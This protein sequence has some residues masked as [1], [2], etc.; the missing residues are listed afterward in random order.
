MNGIRFFRYIYLKL[1]RIND[2]PERVAFGLGIGVF[3]GV[4][5]GMGP[6][7][8]L[9][10]AVILRANRAA[11][12]V[13]SILTNTWLSIPVFLAAAKAGSFI[14]GSSYSYLHD[15][16]HIFLKEFGWTALFKV[17]VYKL[18]FPVLAGYVVVSFVIGAAVYVIA[19]LA[20]RNRKIGYRV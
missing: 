20:L 15:Q 6:L 7:V 10:F 8:A 17:S 3:F 13:G 9:F 14:S 19:L 5:P 18:L 1:F 16:W 11:A 4:M 2:S 12:L